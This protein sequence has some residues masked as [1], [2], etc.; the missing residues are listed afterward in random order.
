MS[1]P[2]ARR[3]SPTCRPAATGFTSSPPM[4]TASGT[5]TGASLAFTIAPAW[6]QTWW[7]FGLVALTLLA[8]PAIAAVAW[9]RRRARL[10][11]ARTQTRFEAILAERTRVARE[12]HDTLL[13]GL[14]GR[15]AA[16]GGR[17]R[18]PGRGRQQ[19]CD[20]RQPPLDSGRPGA[21]NAGRDQTVRAR[22]AHALERRP[23]SRPTGRRGAADLCRDGDRG[24]PHADRHGTS[25]PAGGR[26][27]ARQH[28][29]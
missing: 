14:A 8:T 1:A 6:N 24:P 23:A 4:T 25:L 20:R 29:Q 5:P 11:A 17:R 13:N 16:T 22:H 28:R 26:G 10:A 3:S 19:R 15:G 7:F 18:T 27:G 12:L 9:Q 2:A 21:A